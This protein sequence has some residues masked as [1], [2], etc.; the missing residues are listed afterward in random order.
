MPIT[1]TDLVSLVPLTTLTLIKWFRD[2]Y[3][4]NRSHGVWWKASRVQMQ[5][6]VLLYPIWI[7]LTWTMNLQIRSS[8]SLA[9]VTTTGCQVLEHMTSTGLLNDTFFQTRQQI[10]SSVFGL[11][12]AYTY[13]VYHYMAISKCDEKNQVEAHDCKCC[14]NASG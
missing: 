8:L 6:L 5:I 9:L 13:T 4:Y 12:I 10:V 2:R 7:F 11:M 14:Y 3:L 1:N